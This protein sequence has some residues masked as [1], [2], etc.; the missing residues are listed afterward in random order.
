[1]IQLLTNPRQLATAYTTAELSTRQIL[2]QASIFLF[3]ASLFFAIDT[4]FILPPD[5]HL[6]AS[7]LA[8]RF[9]VA[10]GMMF[11]LYIPMTTLLWAMLQKFSCWYLSLAVPLPKIIGLSAL[12][13]LY[14]ALLFLVSLTVFPF[15]AQNAFV[16]EG[17]LFGLNIGASFLLIRL[18]TT[19]YQV[20]A[21]VT[22]QKALKTALFPLVL[23]LLI[24]GSTLLLTVL[25][26][27]PRLKHLYP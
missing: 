3:L 18:F 25:S 19:F 17:L 9:F 14:Y 1:M 23:I 4:L 7:Q 16:T 24:Y 8:L 12:S 2:I 21:D 27:L 11:L 15:H 13:I 10:F 6:T 20:A 22:F 26:I 5:L